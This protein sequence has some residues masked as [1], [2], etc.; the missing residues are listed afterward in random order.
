MNI[1]IPADLDRLDYEIGLY[2]KTVHQ[3]IE[4]VLNHPDDWDIGYCE[5]CRVP[6]VI[7]PSGEP[8]LCRWCAEKES[9]Q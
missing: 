6:T 7:I 3:K 1:D 2:A 8:T 9:E 5:T 4:Q